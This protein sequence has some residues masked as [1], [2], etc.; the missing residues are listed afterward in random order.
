MRP[1]CPDSAFL[2]DIQRSFCPRRELKELKL[3]QK[4]EAI[5]GLRTI[6]HTN[7][8]FFQNLNVQ[9]YVDLSCHNKKHR[10]SLRFHGTDNFV[11]F[12][13]CF[14]VF[15]LVAA[16]FPWPVSSLRSKA[17]KR[18]GAKVASVSI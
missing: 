17:P 9:Q 6:P 14:S 1:F 7:V 12:A 11:S 5:E 10:I 16:L 8:A 13:V 4:K 15:C 18:P 2:V 3:W